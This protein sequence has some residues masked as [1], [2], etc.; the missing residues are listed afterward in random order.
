MRDL[1]NNGLARSNR[2]PALIV[3]CILIA[4]V[5]LACASPRKV[6]E[7]MLVYMEAGDH[8]GAVMVLDEAKDSAY[9]DKNAFLYYLER[10]MELHYAGEYEE[11]NVSFHEATRLAEELYTVSI[12]GEVAT[13]MVNDNAR[14]YYGQNF[15]RALVH[16][17]SA[18]NYQALDQIDEALV[19][20]RRLNYFL[21]KLTVDGETNT[22]DDDA[23][24]HYLAG[25]FFAESG[26]LDEAFIAYKKAL[27]AYA[28]YAGKYGVKTP[29]TLYVDAA[30]T[31]RKLGTWAV[32]ELRDHYGEIEADLPKEGS[33]QAVVLHYNGRA[34]VKIDVFIDMAFGDGW[35]YVNQIKA[36]D[37]GSEDVAR[38]SGMISAI[39]GTE[40]VR[41]A[42]PEYRRIP[43]VIQ[44][45][46]VRA[47]E[48]GQP[49]PAVLVENIAAIAE[50]DLSDHIARIR[51]KAIARAMVK[52]AI[53]RAAEE[54]AKQAG[55]NYGAL[56]GAL[57]KVTSAVVR[58]ATEV[59]DKRAWFTAPEEIW[60]SQ[61]DLPAG[62]HTLEITYHDAQGG[63]VSS[64]EAEVTITPGRKSFV[65]VRTLQ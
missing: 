19:E 10:G 42:F 20:I 63:I 56:A 34:P 52:Y 15:E 44:R 65:V 29:A 35:A 12:S 22:Y 16:A 3:S 58:G 5:S 40:S 43:K 18:L 1:S 36:E 31:A 38:A 59:A 64:E 50:K 41:I 26:E 11:S 51:A 57:I 2:R 17:F 60:I 21:R 32:D 39:A 46:S 30:R 37:E 7:D 25:I 54:A 27:D 49:V 47:G 45:M 9:K 53:G 61:V 33:G 23:F 55:G 8:L 62:D 6:N 28:A 14:P 48:D 24:A 13:F 4:A